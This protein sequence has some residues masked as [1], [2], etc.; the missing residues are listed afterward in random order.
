MALAHAK[1]AIQAYR[2]SGGANGRP[3][4]LYFDD[5]LTFS[6]SPEMHP[7]LFKGDEIMHTNLRPASL[8]RGE[9]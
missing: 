4:N 3:A 8:C 5:H 1:I 6:L 7:L 2:D 9:F